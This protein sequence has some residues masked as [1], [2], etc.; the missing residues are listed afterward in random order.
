M[1]EIRCLVVTFV[2]P[3]IPTRAF[4][5]CAYEDGEE[6]R[7]QYGYGPTREAAVAHLFEQLD[8][9]EMD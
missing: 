3:P 5:W 9:E 4:D 8:E 7:Q 1:P 6:E 2:Y